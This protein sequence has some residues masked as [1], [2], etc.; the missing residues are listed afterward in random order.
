ML[1]KKKNPIPNIWEVVVTICLQNIFIATFSQLI[2][3]GV[4]GKNPH[5]DHN[6]KIPHEANTLKVRKCIMCVITVTWRGRS[7]AFRESFF[8]CMS[9]LSCSDWTQQWIEAFCITSPNTIWL[10]GNNLDCFHLVFCW[11]ESEMT[12]HHVIMLPISQRSRFCNP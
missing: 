6:M 9:L 2:S 1:H 8:L 11:C 3:G 10:V 12:H 5:S 4:A 7:L